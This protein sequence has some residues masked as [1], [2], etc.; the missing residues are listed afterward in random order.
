M[1]RR[2]IK[3]KVGEIVEIKWVDSGM[4][5]YRT[6]ATVEEMVCGASTDWGKVVAWT[7]TCRKRDTIVLMQGQA[8]PDGEPTLNSHCGAVWWPSV[9]ECDKLTKAKAQ[10]M[11]KKR[12]QSS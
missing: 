7:T 2:P 9:V 3:P 4:N 10:R 6:G 5:Y 8:D 1:P 11:Q 12:K